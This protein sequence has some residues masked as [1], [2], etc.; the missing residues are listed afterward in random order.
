MKTSRFA[1]V[2]LLLT[3]ASIVGCH[4][5]SFRSNASAPAAAQSVHSPQNLAVEKRVDA[6]LAQMSL[7]EKISLITGSSGSTAPGLARLNLPTLKLSDGPVGTRIDGPSTAYPSAIALAATWNTD[8]ANQF[9]Q[10]MGR[11]GRARGDHFILGP[12][13]NI[14]R[15]PV[16]GRNSEYLGEDPYLTGTMAGAIVR[17]IQSQGVVATIK[18]FAA[19]NQEF[20]R[21]TVS[22]EA[23]QRTLR[24]IYLRG[25]QIAIQNGH[26]WAVMC[27][28]N[29][30]NGVY[31]SAN[32][33]L[34]TTVLKD[35]WGYNGMVMSDWGAT[36]DTLGPANAGLDLEMPGRKWFTPDLLMPL[37]QSG[38][39]SQATIDDKVRRILRVEVSMGFL[40]RPQKDPK[41][42]LDDPASRNVALQIARQGIVLLK[43]QNNILPL[44]RSKIKTIAVVGPNADPAVTGI[45]GSSHVIPMNPISVLAGIQKIAANKIDVSYFPA[46]KQ[47]AF[48]E[49]IQ[50]SSYE[51]QDPNAHGLQA[52]FFA[53]K[54]LSGKPAL[55]R[56]YKKIDVLWTRKAP[57]PAGLAND[58]LSIRWTG[59]IR[60]AADGTYTFSLATQNRARVFL[61]GQQVIDMWS[62]RSTPQ[63]DVQRQLIGG[64]TYDLRV[65]F[66]SKSQRCAIQFGWGPS[67]PLLTSDDLDKIAHADAVILCVGFNHLLESEGADRTYALPAEQEQLVEKI[68][69]LTPH[70]IVLVNAGG[71][72][73]MAPWIDH[74]A[75]LIQAWYPGEAGGTA[76]ADILFGNVC[77]SGRLP[78]TFEKQWQD[79]PAFGNYP[80]QD[81]KVAYKEGVFVGYRWFDA[82]Q[83][84]PRFPFGFGLSYTTFQL[85]NLRINRSIGNKDKEDVQADVTNT[86]Q[87]AGT[88]VIQFYTGQDHPSLPTPP[89]QLAGFTRVDLSPGQTKTIHFTLNDSTLAYWHPDTQQWQTD[90][91]AYHLWLGESSRNLPLTHPFNWPPASRP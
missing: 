67:R 14:Y 26:P 56:Q 69:A 15:V 11:D 29:L 61:D 38:K 8:L 6:L 66:F 44:D 52:E 55:I 36:H 41:T 16:C 20:H 46:N 84:E 74:A 87:R 1:M 76:I 62:A 73:E 42:P 86:G 12:A 19:N 78:A 7:A 45:G 51:P 4:A 22:V 71:N 31:C 82:K 80:G 83:I 79:S 33:W 28:Y 9:G 59:K 81:D 68:V 24:Q 5:P 37:I 57:A 72:I 18:H 88:D 58:N 54:D 47:H 40:D 90:P 2:I 23:D 34:L 30:I 13:M 27:A 60:P 21:R 49:L 77:P 70:A 75:G 32:P 53:N 43:N 3:I 65:E 10:A 50:N 25:F 63:V 17:G 85:K 48:D 64:K 39:I 89:R 35:E 91:G